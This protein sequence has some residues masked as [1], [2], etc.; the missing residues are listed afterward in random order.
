M[1]IKLDENISRHL[2]L[3]IIQKGHECVTAEDEG[4][5]SKTD[6][7]VGAAAKSEGR[8][9]FK[10]GQRGQ[11]AT[12]NNLVFLNTGLWCHSKLVGHNLVSEL[13]GH[14]VTH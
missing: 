10:K 5:L 2:K 7:E 1:K 11:T 6:V 9:L 14:W 4:L 8:M 3:V 12:F 13:L